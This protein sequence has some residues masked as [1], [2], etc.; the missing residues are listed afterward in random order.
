MFQPNQSQIKYNNQFGATSAVYFSQQQTSRDKIIQTREGSENKQLLQY[1]ASQIVYGPSMKFN[2]PVHS[3]IAFR[4]TSKE[5]NI[6]IEDPL[7]S[8]QVRQPSPNVKKQREQ[9]EKD[10]NKLID[11]SKTLQENLVLLKNNISMNLNKKQPDPRLTKESTITNTGL[12]SRMKLQ[13]VNVTCKLNSPFKAQPKLEVCKSLSHNAFGNLKFGSNVNKNP[14]LINNTSSINYVNMNNNY[15][16]K[17][18]DELQSQKVNTQNKIIKQTNPL[19][20][21]IENKLKLKISSFLGRGKF[22]DVHMAIDNRTGLIF[23]LKIIKKQTVIDH[24]MQQQLA[25][26]IAIQSKLQHPNIVKMFGQSYDQQYIYMMLE[27]CNNGEL[28]QHQYKQPNKRFNEKEASNF[29]MQILSAIQYMHNQGFMHRDL[30]TENI[31]LSLN[32]IKL[33]DLGCVRE[34]PKYEDRR[35]TFCGT[36]DYIAPEVIKDE[37]YDERCDAWQIAILA[38]ELVAGNTPFSE[39]PRDDDAIMENILNNKFDLPHFFS[40]SLKDFVIRGLQQ[41]P[42]HRI[43]IDQMLLHKWIVENIKTDREYLF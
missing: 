12:S 7:V 8:Q 18:L 14:T 27:F 32:Y 24:E 23:A 5:L 26:E 38:Y 41:S 29:I 17:L 28:F 37:G 22:S 9:M 43:S 21:Q 20:I 6:T 15:A 39:F 2:S 1:P 42:D 16:K 13:K 4:K 19:Y 33:C 35:N 3:N 34:I 36:V 30:K 31:L 40:P 11:K 25:R 10:W